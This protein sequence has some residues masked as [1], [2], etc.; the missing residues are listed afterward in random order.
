M[1][2][3]YKHACGHAAHPDPSRCSS[4]PGQRAQCHPP[5]PTE[6]L[7]AA[8][9]YPVVRRPP[10]SVGASLTP[11]NNQG[12][13]RGARCSLRPPPQRALLFSRTRLT[14][15]LAG[16]EVLTFG[17]TSPEP[18]HARC[19]VWINRYKV[20]EQV[21]STLDIRIGVVQPGV[22]STSTFSRHRTREQCVVP[23]CRSSRRTISVVLATERQVQLG[24]DRPLR[25]RGN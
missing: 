13:R 18:A 9:T 3:L 19:A 5:H 12:R 7:P 15:T 10:A 24:A 6:C 25:P 8:E 23:S 17:G 20:R 21:D 11:S 14:Q 22:S 2:Q 16:M 1:P 4:F